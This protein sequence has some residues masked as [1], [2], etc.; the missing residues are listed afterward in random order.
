[1]GEVDR[2]ILAALDQAPATVAV[3]RGPELRYTYFNDLYRH[4]AP[5]LQIGDSF[6]VDTEQGQRF[7][8]LAF[9]VVHS[10]QQLQLHELP[11]TLKSGVQAYFDLLLHPLR[12]QNGEFDGVI[13]I[14]TDVTK[15]VESRRALE[16][17][18]ERAHR[19][20]AQLTTL[21]ERGPFSVITLDP[22]GRVLYIGGGGIY[23]RGQDP[24]EIVGRNALEL[25]QDD[26]AVL[27]ALRRA[28]TGEVF[29]TLV[30]RPSVTYEVFYSPVRD[31]AGALE[32]IVGVGVDVSRRLRAEEE[33]ARIH[34][35]MLQTQK[36]ESLGVLAGGIAHDFNNLL[37]VIQGNA[38]VALARL[39]DK[40]PVRDP[41]DDILRAALRASDLTRQ[42]LAYSGKGRFQIGPLDLRQQVSE[43]GNLLR[44]SI[45]KKVALRIEQ[46]SFLASACRRAATCGSQSR[47]PARGWI[48][49]SRRASSIPSSPPSPPAAASGW[50]R[51]WA[52]C[53]ATA[54]RSASPRRPGA[55]P[56]SRC[57]CRRPARAR[58]RP[59]RTSRWPRRARAPCW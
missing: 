36:L 55:A 3:L 17:Q 35:K 38:Q 19:A 28:L 40:D 46:P 10:G 15:S 25:Y 52:S 33:R 56:A 54:A 5:G 57:C 59:P 44:T 27:S 6:G 11:V 43:I 41:I 20:E 9:Q 1:M 50:R 58:S 37:T 53:A 31:A 47:T 14:G 30:Q 4:V 45:S 7:R 13:L 26:P 2:L 22:S 34:D 12:N 29:S 18:S 21:L 39:A 24:V 16:A 48:R 51:C 8:E 49:R 42:M 32:M 23:R